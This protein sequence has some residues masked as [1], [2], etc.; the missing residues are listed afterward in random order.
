MAEKDT[1]ATVRELP[2]GPRDTSGLTSRQRRVLEV[3]RDS[4]QRRGYPPTMREVGEAVGLTSTSSV[5]HQ[6]TTLQRKGFLRRDPHRPRTVELRMPDTSPPHAEPENPPNA[7]G[8]SG[9]WCVRAAAYRIVKQLH[10]TVHKML[11]NVLLKLVR[12]CSFL[13]VRTAR[14]T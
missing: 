11:E 3:I 2:D 10:T 1:E 5:S 6:L 4:L 14:P 7:D 9:Q 12:N 8:T 13:T